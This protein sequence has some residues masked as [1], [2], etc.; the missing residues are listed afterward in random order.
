MSRPLPVFSTSRDLF[1]TSVFQRHTNLDLNFLSLRSTGTPGRILLLAE[2]GHFFEPEFSGLLALLEVEVA[3]FPFVAGFHPDVYRSEWLLQYLEKRVGEFDRVF[4]FDAF[5]VFFQ[6]DPFDR[7]VMADHMTFVSEGLKLREQHNNMEMIAGCFGKEAAISAGPNPLIC[8]G[9]VAGD[10]RVYVEYLK[11]LTG[12]LT[13][14]HGCPTDQQQINHL[15]WN[16]GL[17][18]AGIK[19]QVLGC[20]GPVNSM[21]FC[22]KHRLRFDGELFDISEN[23]VE[24][25]TAVA[26]HFRRWGDIVRNY[27]DRCGL[28][29]KQEG[30]RRSRE[31]GRR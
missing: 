16:G 21:Y 27:F 12:N 24:L 14:W 4:Y 2:E 19:F 15:V 5:D 8:S 7:L 31:R 9:T 22:W 28:V 20:D 26:H 25:N 23:A 18:E 11:V 17:T 6:R 30:R 1:V 3:V 10:A 13:R 29:V